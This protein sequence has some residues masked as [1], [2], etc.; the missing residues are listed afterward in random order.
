MEIT[1]AEELELSRPKFL[2]KIINKTSTPKCIAVY[3]YDDE[4]WHEVFLVKEEDFQIAYENLCEVYE[5]WNKNYFERDFD[6][7]DLQSFCRSRLEALYILYK[8]HG[9]A[10][11]NDDHYHHDEM[12][13]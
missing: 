4:E 6:Y 5:Y 8:V 10:H 13:G 9:Y 12:I 3:P 11:Q 1:M 7:A 2:S